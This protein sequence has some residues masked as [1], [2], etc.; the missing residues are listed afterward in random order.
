MAVQ[1]NVTLSVVFRVLVCS[2]LLAVAIGI[3]MVLK[4]TAPKPATSDSAAIMPRV[5]VI[6]A[7]P[8]PVRRE[9]EG[10]GTALAMDSANVPARVTAV[11]IERPEQIR[12]GQP[13]TQ[14]QLLVRLDES[15]FQR[16]VEIA[17]EAIRDIDAQLARIKVEDES[18]TRRA[19]L[20]SEEVGL[21]RADYERVRQAFERE[22]ARQRELDEAQRK[23]NAIQQA[24][25]A[26]R[27][28]LDKIVPRRAALLAQQQSH[29]ASM[30]LATLSAER[31]RIVSPMNGVLQ[32][33]DVEVG[34][35]ITAGQRVAR[36]VN[37]A[38]IEV[39][40]LLPAAAR[41]HVSVDDEVRLFEGEMNWSARVARISPVDDETTRTMS[42][43]AEVN[44]ERAN[45]YLLPPG[46]FVRGVVRSSNTETRW[47][48]PR[49]ALSGDRV[50][51]IDNGRV[52]SRNVQV[53]FNMQADFPSLGLS[54]QQWVVL[55]HPLPEKSLVV[56]DG[57][58][59]LAEGAEVVPIV[60]NQQAR[61][62]DEVQ[63]TNG[64]DG[65]RDSS[66]AR[67]KVQ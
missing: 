38:R 36:V 45:G 67:S 44:Q 27:E 10:F 32:S 47:V 7:H 31:T 62:S 57:A 20:A 30:R 56:I 48:V 40:L 14:G 63:V 59:A 17:T 55:K 65:A 41:P 60:S 3:F 12:A 50:L 39:P 5:Q 34:E 19:E 43:F 35:N 9:W 53:D 58:R 6:E 51:L 13:V 33:V 52:R 25:V 21:A 11:V 22:A 4:N 64:E 24:E 28:E 49:R 46:R 54:D 1:R 29:E 23:L 66:I 61:R 8:V 42:V 16:Q 2:A 15:D 26:T 37:P 18:W